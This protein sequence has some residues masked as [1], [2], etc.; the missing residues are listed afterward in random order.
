M[1]PFLLV[2]L[3]VPIAEVLYTAGIIIF[4]HSEFLFIL[5]PSSAEVVLCNHPCLSVVH[6]WSVFIY[7][8]NS[9]LVVSSFF[10]KL[11]HHKGTKMT[12]FLKKNLEVSQIGK[13]PILRVF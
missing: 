9:P 4:V 1:T 12:F 7:L 2:L 3:Y 5:D 6:L 13:E 10:I 11:G 8:R